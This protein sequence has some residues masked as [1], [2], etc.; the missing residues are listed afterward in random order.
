MV[1]AATLLPGEGV[2]VLGG[3]SQSPPRL[4]RARMLMEDL[5][6]VMD[7]TDGPDESTD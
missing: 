1:H 6:F 3:D 7:A 5:R 4:S 2:L